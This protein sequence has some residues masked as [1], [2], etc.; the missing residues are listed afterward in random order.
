MA[1]WPDTIP[2][3]PILNGFNEEPQ[4]NVGS[5]KPEVGPPKARRRSTARCWLSEFVFRMTNAEV[6]SFWDFYINTLQDGTE[7]FGF[8][9]PIQ[10]VEYSWMFVPGEVPKAERVSPT[11]QTITFRL[12]RLP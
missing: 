7:S 9:H 10:K 3:C 6:A 1:E 4:V 12:L 2:A 11:T 8:D 5:F